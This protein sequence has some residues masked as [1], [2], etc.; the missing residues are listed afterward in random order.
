MHL[1]QT[2]PA[3]PVPD[4]ENAQAYYRDSLGF[5][6]AW[7]SVK[8]KLGA[9]S[10]GELVI[11]FREVD[12]PVEPHELWVFSTD[13]DEAAR[14]FEDLGAD[15]VDPLADRPWGLRQFTICDENGHLFHI[16]CDL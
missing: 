7:H 1:S 4:V 12:G 6:I 9:V 13:V 10:K 15:I 2:V 5:D 14:H 16:H 3:L 8:G 11:F